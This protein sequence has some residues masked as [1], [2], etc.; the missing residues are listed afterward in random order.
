M[1]RQQLI[2]VYHQL[3]GPSAEQQSFADPV[4]QKQ[5]GQSCQASLTALKKTI[6][7]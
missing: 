7:Q 4:L 5:L 2:S 6:K 1:A 3:A